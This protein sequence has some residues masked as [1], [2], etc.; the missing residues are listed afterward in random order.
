MNA[1]IAG[2]TITYMDRPWLTYEQQSKLIAALRA[3]NATLRTCLIDATGQRDEYY[4][5]L[6]TRTSALQGELDKLLQ[7]R[8]A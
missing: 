1:T 7:E 3:E 2:A 6:I 8:T 4:R 5:Q